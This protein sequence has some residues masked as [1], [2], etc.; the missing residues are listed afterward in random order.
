MI[1]L[2]TL[3]GMVR[4]RILVNFRVDPEVIQRQLPPP[5]RPKL[6][7]NWAMAGICLIRLEQIRPSGLPAVFGRSSENAAHRIAV[8]W[9]D[10]T[11]EEREGV[12]IPR[13]DTGALLNHLV[14]GWLFPGE[15]QRAVFRVR[16][17]LVSLDLVLNTGGGTA[18][19]RLRAHASDRLP[20]TSRFASLKEAT[21]FFSAGTVGYSATRCDTR[22]D[23]LRMNAVTW[24][25]EAL[26]VETL[27]SSY[28]ADSDR[29]PPGSLA[30]DCALIMRDTEHDWQRIPDLRTDG[31]A[32]VARISGR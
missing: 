19:V 14:G 18:D 32:A 21:E 24:R 10:E 5:F 26:D 30:F 3:Q 22:L 4:R 13:R 8:T 17:D 16:D 6:L 11:G 23:G 20:S 31:R 1:K 15:H 7:G 12:Y 28:F 25:M 27:Y 29:F 2:S 9:A